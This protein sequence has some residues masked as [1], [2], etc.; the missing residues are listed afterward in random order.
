M[1]RKVFDTVLFRNWF[2]HLL[3]RDIN[4]AIDAHVQAILSEIE[5]EYDLATFSLDTFVQWVEQ[6]RN[7]PIELVP[8]RLSAA[9]SG[10][11]LQ[12]MEKDFL[13]YEAETLAVHQVHIQLH[14]LSHMLCGHGAIQVD[15]SSDVETL[16]QLFAYLVELFESPGNID[17]PS[18][19]LLLRTQRSIPQEL[20]A[21]RLS[22]LILERVSA[23]QFEIMITRPVSYSKMAVDVYEAMRM[24]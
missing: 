4:R 13:F 10:G 5:R 2:P 8:L 1:L 22:E 20:E 19:K 15:E 17:A 9:V 11:W 24:A 18:D 6:K 23:H 16:N 14:E 3:S 12:L 7:R 21:E